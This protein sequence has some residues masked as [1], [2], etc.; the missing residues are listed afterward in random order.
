MAFQTAVIRPAFALI[1]ARVSVG[2]IN[3]KE[4]Y[5]N[6]AMPVAG[7]ICAG[8][9]GTGNVGALSEP[10]RSVIPGLPQFCI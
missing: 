3:P 4:V 7:R 1:T 9:V 6:P 5:T 2:K 10:P 8:K